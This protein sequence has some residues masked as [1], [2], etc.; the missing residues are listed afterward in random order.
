MHDDKYD[1][2]ERGELQYYLIKAFSE[3]D[4][5]EMVGLQLMNVYGI[6]TR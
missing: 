1:K 6:V 4:K 5:A 2:K 3:W